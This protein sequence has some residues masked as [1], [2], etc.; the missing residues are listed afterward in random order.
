MSAAC[1]KMLKTSHPIEDVVAIIQI[2]LAAQKMDVMYRS[3]KQY[4]FHFL[5]SESGRWFD[6]VRPADVDIMG[7]WSGDT[8]LVSIEVSSSITS[9]GSLLQRDASTLKADTLVKNLQALLD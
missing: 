1:T 6:N 8:V 5:A 7:Q 3:V 4:T 2:V 9:F